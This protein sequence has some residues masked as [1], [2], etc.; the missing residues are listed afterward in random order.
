M[1]GPGIVVRAF[2]GASQMVPLLLQFSKTPELS[3]SVATYFYELTRGSALSYAN[4]F[5]T[6]DQK[7]KFLRCPD[8]SQYVSI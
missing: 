5:R 6:I 1:D 4:E 2:F 8:R 3:V 7:A